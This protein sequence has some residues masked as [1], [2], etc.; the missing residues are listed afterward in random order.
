MKINICRLYSNANSVYFQS[1]GTQ[2]ITIYE[3]QS[4]HYNIHR[5][6]YIHYH[7]DFNGSV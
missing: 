6:K 2:Y 4:T 7:F 3:R 5:Q 1:V